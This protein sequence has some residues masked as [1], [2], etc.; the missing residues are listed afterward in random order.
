M[1]VLNMFFCLV[2]QLP[3]LAIGEPCSSVLLVCQVF[4]KCFVGSTPASTAGVVYE[5]QMA[6]VYLFKESLSRDVVRALHRLGPGYKVSLDA[7]TDGSIR[8]F[9]AS[10]PFVTQ[11]QF[12]FDAE[13]DVCLTPEEKKVRTVR[14]CVH[15]LCRLGLLQQG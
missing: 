10:C 11:S 4:D 1:L 14:A 15:T 2:H 5:G 12:K 3:Y 6:A 8:S 9:F 7:F 13:C